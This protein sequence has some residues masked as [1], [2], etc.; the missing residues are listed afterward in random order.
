MTTEEIF[1]AI[2][3]KIRKIQPIYGAIYSML[4][5]RRDDSIETMGVS[6]REIVYNEEFIHSVTMD[7]LVFINLHEIAHYSLL[8]PIRL[9]GRLPTLFNVACDLY[10]NKL[11]MKEYNLEIGKTKSVQRVDVKPPKFGL[12][13]STCGFDIEVDVEKDCVESIYAKLKDKLDK[14]LSDLGLDKFVM[15]ISYSDSS[16]KN[17]DIDTMKGRVCEAVTKAKLAGAEC[18]GIMRAIEKALNVNVPW[19]KIVSKYLIDEVQKE[20]SYRTIDSRMNYQEAIF[21][22]NRSYDKSKLDKVKI[23]I[24][25]SGSVTD[26]E[27][28][29]FQSAIIQLLKK[30]RVGA[31]LLYWDGKCESSGLV[32][33]KTSFERIPCIGGGGTTPECLFEYFKS[34]KCK[35]KPS[36]SI[37]L[38]DGYFNIDALRKY[39]RKF[40]DTVWLICKNGDM[41]FKAPFGKVAFIR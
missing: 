29:E 3:L 31:E 32:T 37:I 9:E 12:Y 39:D 14:K 19:E 1:A 21:P 17:V 36:L 10:V 11:L 13:D 16:S 34:N 26:R 23:C 8:H 25:T 33:D 5:K 28:G 18:G 40:K 6:A 38:T 7:E 24:D 4:P 15:D 35:I 30:Y 22:G 20:T 41:N 27:L 2:M